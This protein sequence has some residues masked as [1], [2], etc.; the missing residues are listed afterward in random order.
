MCDSWLW[1]FVKNSIA[2]IADLK[3]E[4]CHIFNSITSVMLLTGLFVTLGNEAVVY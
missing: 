3:G 1:S 4:I 2:Q